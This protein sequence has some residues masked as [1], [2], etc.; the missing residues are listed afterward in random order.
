MNSE[1]EALEITR[2]NAREVTERIQDKA[3]EVDRLRT[4]Q[5]VDEREREARLVQLTGSKSVSRWR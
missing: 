2:A 4:V 1:A 5:G 3:Q